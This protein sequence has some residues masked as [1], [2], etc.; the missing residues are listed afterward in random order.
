[1]KGLTNLFTL[2]RRNLV[3]TL[4]GLVILF[5]LAFHF[6][7]GEQVT[8]L[9]AEYDD[10]E[11]KRSRMLK[12]IRNSIELDEDL[13]TLNA[14][15][16]T[17]RQR[18]FDAED[19]ATNQNY[20]YQIESATGARLEKMQQFVKPLPDARRNKKERMLAMK[21]AYQ[22]ISY[23]M[24]VQGSYESILMF[25]R[26]VEGG[27][28]FSVLDGFSVV[29]TEGFEGRPEVSMRITFDVLGTKS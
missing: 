11:I 12:N 5:C 22:K 3:L 16:S 8:R 29:S 28:A 15:N 10:L 14:L 25:L 19:L 21:S 9:A 27:E 13:E 20:F 17:I 4:S 2:A 7:R 6:F 1:M 26:A 18:L 24:S 23:D